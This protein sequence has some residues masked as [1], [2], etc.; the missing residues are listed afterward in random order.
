MKYNYQSPKKK[1]TRGYVLGIFLLL[2][3]LILGILYMI[4]RP[5]SNETADE[6]QNPTVSTQETAA[7]ST[8]ETSES[9]TQGFVLLPSSEPTLQGH[10][11]YFTQEDNG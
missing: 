3:L 7:E 2:A 1:G 5:Q 4:F 10:N 6:K 11:G 8:P 9:A